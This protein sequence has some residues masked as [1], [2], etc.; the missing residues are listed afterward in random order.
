M[1]ETPGFGEFLADTFDALASPDGAFQ[2]GVIVLCALGAWLIKRSVLQR[3][4]FRSREPGLG[5]RHDAWAAA[6]EHLLL[7]AAA[8]GLLL[9]A[10]GIV[11]R[12]QSVAA[13]LDTALVLLTAWL[14]IRAVAFALTRSTAGAATAK[15]WMTA[16][17]TTVWVIVALHL[18]GWLGDVL[19]W[20]DQTALVF[21]ETR[22]SALMLVRLVL[23]VAVL[24]VGALWLSRAVEHRIERSQRFDVGTRIGLAKFT[25]FT[26]LA[27]AILSSLRMAGI[28]LTALAVFGGALGVG[29]GFGLQRIASNLVSGII[30]VFDGSIRP[31]DVVTIGDSVGEIKA[32]RARYV[33]VRGRDGVE[34]LIPNETLIT[35]NVINWTYSDRRVRIKLP[36]QIS[37]ADDPESAM[38]VMLDAARANPR[39]IQDPEPICLLSEFGDNGINLELRVWINDP[40]EGIGNIRS[41]IYLTVWREFKNRNITIPFPQRDVY[42]KNN[43]APTSP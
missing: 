13:W 39:V 42:I 12:M 23:S 4:R 3:L 17:S 30:L 29:L 9:I 24:L 34:T 35:T 33:V 26:L 43:T 10:R 25:R 27:L 8:L 36:V 7:P 19:D 41:E 20:L 38:R 6:A 31:G 18:A 22:F 16:I 2:L 14:V 11:S 37:Y 1:N 15:S 28:D 40:E 5:N 32:L 21:G